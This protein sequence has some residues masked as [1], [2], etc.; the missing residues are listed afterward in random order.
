M[1]FDDDALKRLRTRYGEG[2]GVVCP[3]KSDPS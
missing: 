3:L 1:A 2:R